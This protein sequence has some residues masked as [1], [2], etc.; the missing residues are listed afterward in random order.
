ML[1]AHI[2]QQTFARYFVMNPEVRNATFMSDGAACQFKQRF[3]IASFTFFNECFEATVL[4]HFIT[5]SHGNG[6]NGM[7]GKVT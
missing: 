7:C 1:C 3:Q 5:T 2:S 6:I 4:W